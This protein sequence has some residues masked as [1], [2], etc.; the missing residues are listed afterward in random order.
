MLQAA[1]AVPPHLQ[2]EKDPLLRQLAPLHI[3]RDYLYQATERTSGRAVT[4]G[5]GSALCR[6]CIAI[7]LLVQAALTVPDTVSSH[8]ACFTR[9]PMP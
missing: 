2:T 3:S 1:A 5:E 9:Y 8:A 7:A 6:P 4:T